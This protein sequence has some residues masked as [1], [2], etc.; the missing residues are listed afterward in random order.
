M[1][2]AHS[3]GEIILISPGVF[4]ITVISVPHS[5]IAEAADLMQLINCS[6]INGRWDMEIL[7]KQC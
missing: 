3:Q 4:H 2:T 7:Q 5:C 6:I 1:A